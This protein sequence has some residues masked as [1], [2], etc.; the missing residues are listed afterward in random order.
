ML[1]QSYGISLDRNG[2]YARGRGRWRSR[3]RGGGQPAR[4]SEPRDDHHGRRFSR[5]TAI[6]QSAMDGYA[7]RACAHI[8]Q[9]SPL[10]RGET[11][12]IRQVIQVWPRSVAPHQTKLRESLRPWI[13]QPELKSIGGLDGC[14]SLEAETKAI[15][16]VLRVPDAGPHERCRGCRGRRP[17]ACREGTRGRFKRWRWENRYG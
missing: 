15:P 1:C 5:D 2:A 6:N 17:E 8:E 13:F 3:R 11:T 16:L 7:A 9:V 10:A 14:F 12:L 4:C